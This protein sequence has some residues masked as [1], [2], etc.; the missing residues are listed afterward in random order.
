HAQVVYYQPEE[1]LPPLDTRDSQ[2]PPAPA[3]DQSAAQ[4]PDAEK[5]NEKA[6]RKPDPEFAPQPIISVPPEADNRSQTIVTP[7]NIK[8]KRDVPLPNIVA[9]SNHPQ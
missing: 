9:W 8:L 2:A 7:P 6:A 5:N 4:K 1:Y 3:A